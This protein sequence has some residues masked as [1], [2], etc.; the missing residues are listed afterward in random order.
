MSEINMISPS[1]SSVVS[2]NR[3]RDLGHLLLGLG[4]GIMLSANYALFAYDAHVSSI[5]LSA[6]ILN[7]VALYLIIW[8]R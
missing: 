6:S 8:K 7:S 2:I 3:R 4:I 1:N 5:M